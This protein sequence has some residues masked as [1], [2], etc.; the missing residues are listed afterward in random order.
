MIHYEELIINHNNIYLPKHIVTCSRGERSEQIHQVA[1]F[2]PV[3][4]AMATTH[5]VTDGMNIEE[6]L[7]GW[8]RRT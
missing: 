6:T 8:N 2:V 1:P 5:P 3:E 4:V 7:D